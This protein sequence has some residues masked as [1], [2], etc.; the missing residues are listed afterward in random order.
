M[1]R[2]I[3]IKDNAGKGFQIDHHGFTPVEV[4]GVLRF[5]EKSMFVKTFEGGDPDTAKN[6]K[7]KNKK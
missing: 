6:P 3:T 2:T 7:K 1:A 5:V 4:I